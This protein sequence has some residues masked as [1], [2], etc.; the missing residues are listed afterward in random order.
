MI[1]LSEEILVW[2]IVAVVIG[3]MLVVL[4]CLD[5]WNFKQRLPR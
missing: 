1:E 3:L 4:M 5:Y 2:A